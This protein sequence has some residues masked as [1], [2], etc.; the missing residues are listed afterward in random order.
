[1]G[2]HFEFSVVAEDEGWAL[3]RIEEGIAEVR[4]IEKLLTTFDESSQTNQINAMAGKGAVAVDEEV[5]ALIARSLRI[6]KLTQG[7]F[8]ITYGSIDKKLWNFDRHMTALPPREVA[9][10]L[11]RLIDYR[12]V[13]LDESTRS[14]FLKEEGMRIGFGGIG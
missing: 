5:F 12:K 8:D 10:S 1:M 11:V 14:V 3:R 6:S 4:R 13:V 9:A 2:N 7:A